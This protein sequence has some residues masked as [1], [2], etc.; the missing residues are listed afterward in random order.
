MVSESP[1]K[2]YLGVILQYSVAYLLVEGSNTVAPEAYTI[3]PRMYKIVNTKALEIRF[4]TQ[5][6]SGHGTLTLVGIRLKSN[7]SCEKR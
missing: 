2:L 1:R 5:S 7:K 3:L 4:G 6:G